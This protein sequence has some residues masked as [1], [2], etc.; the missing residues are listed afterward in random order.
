MLLQKN[1]FHGY[2]SLRYVYS[3]G[4]TV[5]N[6][7]FAIRYADN[8]RRKTYRCA[9]VVSKKVSKSAVVR[10]R[11]RRRVYEIIRT[12]EPKIQNAPDIVVTVYEAEL[13][14]LPFAELQKSF[15]SL[16]KKTEIIAKN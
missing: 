9:V 11:I 6:P 16:I 5:R 12:F 14:T 10:N 2:N 1:R 7:R 15:D 3:N 8:P 13:A 4:R